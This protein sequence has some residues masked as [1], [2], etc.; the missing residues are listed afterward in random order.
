MDMSPDI[1]SVEA[2]LNSHQRLKRAALQDLLEVVLPTIKYIHNTNGIDFPCPE[3]RIVRA[4]SIQAECT[5]Y[6]IQIYEGLIELCLKSESAL[7]DSVIPEL[8]GENF[9]YSLVS[10]FSFSWVIAHEWLH[11]VKQHNAVAEQLKYSFPRVGEALEI[12]ADLCAIAIIFRLTQRIYVGREKALLARK[13]AMYCVYW[14]LRN[15][16]LSRQDRDHPPMALRLYHMLTKLGQLADLQEERINPYE[17]SEGQHERNLMLFKVVARCE[18][19]FDHEQA[20]YSLLEE[21]TDILHNG[22]HMD[23]YIDWEKICPL[24]EE[25][26]GTTADITKYKPKG[27]IDPV[28]DESNWMISGPGIEVPDT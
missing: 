7:I 12:D 1:Q 3:I 28:F 5:S 27:Y 11:H 24:V 10:K 18:S 26:S 13:V 21:W 15:I 20:G 17:I 19:L 22:R 9:D 14:P 6:V 16:P 25:L 2:Y 4:P 23:F 8:S